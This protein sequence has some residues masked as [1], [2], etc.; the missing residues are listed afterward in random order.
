MPKF[1]VTILY[2][3]AFEKV[4]IITAKDDED[5]ENKA[6]A[7]ANKLE[8]QQNGIVSAEVETIFELE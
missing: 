6:I 5:A 3:K 7:M 4:K 1:E 2:H 8:E